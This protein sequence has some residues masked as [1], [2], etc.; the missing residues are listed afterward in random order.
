M[1]TTGEGELETYI[2][3]CDLV[4]LHVGHEFDRPGAIVLTAT[5]PPSVYSLPLFQLPFP[6]LPIAS[7]YVP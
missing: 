3:R 7:S 4:V 1:S 6:S 2:S 5:D